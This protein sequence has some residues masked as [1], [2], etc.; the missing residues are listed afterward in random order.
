M[1]GGEEE[2]WEMCRRGAGHGKKEEGRAG[3]K[4]V[5]GYWGRKG[6]ERAG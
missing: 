1:C 3:R 5:K 2:T 4:C 6:R